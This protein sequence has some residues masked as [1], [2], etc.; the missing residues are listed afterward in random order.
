MYGTLNICVYSAE[1][2]DMGNSYAF[3]NITLKFKA[4]ADNTIDG[5]TKFHISPPSYN[6]GR[7]PKW[8]EDFVFNLTGETQLNI[9]VYDSNPNNS[10]SVNLFN[11]V[12]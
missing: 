4:V 9:T 11:P 2:F 10:K 8:N 7:Y 6:P 12:W 5:T 1:I 3:N